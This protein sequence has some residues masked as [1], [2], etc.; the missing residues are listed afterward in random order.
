MTRGVGFKPPNFWKLY[1]MSGNV[2]EMTQ[3]YFHG[4]YYQRSPSVSPLATI[5]TSEMSI[6]GGSFTSHE[7]TNRCA[8]RQGHDLI[9]GRLD[10]GFRVVRM[11]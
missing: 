1:D 6:R 5:T 7:E 10:L 2:Y 4:D 3:D 9:S 8:S 11:R